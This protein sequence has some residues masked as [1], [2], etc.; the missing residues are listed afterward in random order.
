MEFLARVLVLVIG[1]AFGIFQTG[2]I[3]G[4]MRGVDIRQHGSGNT[5]ATNTLRT[6]G[7]KGG[8]ITFAGDCLKAVLA[9]W[10]ATL[11]LTDWVYA[12]ALVIQI[13]AGLGAVLG[14]NFPF[15]LNFKGGKGIACTA[16]VAFVVCPATVPVCLTVFVLCLALS[17]YVSLGSILMAL[18]FI[19][20]VFVFNGYGI[21]ELYGTDVME[22]N[23]LAFILGAMAI[24]RHKD[25]IIRLAKGA[26]NKIGK[27]PEITT[28]NQDSKEV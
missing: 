26:E 14:H 28:D 2:Y 8:V 19:I 17:Q 20:Q 6:F 10:V 9:I 24:I 5:G 27:K 18:L 11:L 4:K 3:Y 25:N 1:Y 12:D 21:L 23:I 16:G 13:Y 15:Y 7:W 22:F